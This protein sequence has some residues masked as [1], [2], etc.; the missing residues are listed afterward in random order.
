[1]NL[2]DFTSPP[3]DGGGKENDEGD[4][5]KCAVFDIR[6]FVNATM[7]PQHNNKK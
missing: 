1:L 5:F 2:A 4:E 6:T 7:S 3:G